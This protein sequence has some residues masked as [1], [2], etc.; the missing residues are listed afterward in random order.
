[1]IGSR[2][3]LSNPFVWAGLVGLGLAVV[4]LTALAMTTLGDSDS[5]GG[6]ASESEAGT[7]PPGL[8]ATGPLRELPAE[9]SREVANLTAGTAVNALGRSD[10]GTWI[11]VEVPGQE[12]VAGWLTASSLRGL[13]DVAA[14]PVFQAAVNVAGPTEGASPNPTAP[15][16]SP[17]IANLV[18]QV[19]TSRDNRLAVILG[20]EGNA[21]IDVPVTLLVEGGERHPVDFASQPLRPGGRHEVVLEGEYV[22]RRAQV[23]V[24]ASAPGLHEEHLDDNELVATVE[25]DVPNDIEMVEVRVDP[26]LLITVRNNS[27]I[28]IVGTVTI[29]VRETH[30]S[31]LLVMR[32]DE[33]LDIEAGASHVF[34]F[35]ALRDVDLSRTQIILLTEALNDAIREN[36]GFPR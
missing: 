34:E 10:N 9:T 35:P 1:M 36:D 3:E 13:I 24:T 25:P 17:D 14:L 5:G 18:V 30:P 21:P 15:T 23:A 11:L 19:V 29:A 31:N 4:V 6:S 20:N 2:L 12:G 8:A 27:I 16:P 33:P 7:P 28:P 26:Y 32:V 22:Q